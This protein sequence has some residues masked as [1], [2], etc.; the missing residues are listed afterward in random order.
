[1]PKV[2]LKEKTSEL[3]NGECA[4][5]GE[6]LPQKTKLYDTHRLNPKR[7]GGQYTKANTKVV[8]PVAHMKEHCT[9]RERK[10]EVEQVKM[11][12]DDRNQVMKVVNKISNQLDAG[13]RRVDK[14]TDNMKEWLTEI[15]KQTEKK[16]R[17]IDKNLVQNIMSFENPLVTAALCVKGIGPV[18][19]AYCMSYLD[20]AGFYEDGP[21]KG[22]EKMRHASSAWKYI[23]MHCSSFERYTK[24]ESGGGNKTLRT[25]LHTMALSQIKA[26]GTFLEEK[27]ESKE[28]L[29]TLLKEEIIVR[30]PNTDDKQPDKVKFADQI[31]DKKELVSLLARAKITDIE[32]VVSCWDGCSRGGYRYLYYRQKAKREKSEQITTTR[33]FHEDKVQLVERK[34]KDTMPSHRHGD[35]IRIIIKHFLADYWYVARTLL[36]LKTTPI[37]AESHL[38][39]T[40]R[41]VMPEERGWI[42]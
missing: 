2:A 26:S 14:L 33:I 10:K 7:K 29:E 22:K 35:A 24:G 36:G 39:G 40:H 41:T 11:I 30:R 5:T 25:M 12:I 42:Y 19:I 15:K 8:N 9:H 6:K 38:G 18:T 31:A 1:M 17:E 13:E 34:W 21:N 37:Y 27:I 3:Q 20:I 4:L 23:G 32:N 28:T 16:L